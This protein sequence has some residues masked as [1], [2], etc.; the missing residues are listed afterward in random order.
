MQ[1]EPLSTTVLKAPRNLK[2]ARFIAETLAL[3]IDIQYQKS[4]P[5]REGKCIAKFKDF[6]GGFAL[7]IPMKNEA[8]EWKNCPVYR[9]TRTTIG[10]KLEY[11]PRVVFISQ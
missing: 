1:K 2:D 9:W 4:K 6:D 5:G 10:P 7:Y 11:D 3:E 8:G